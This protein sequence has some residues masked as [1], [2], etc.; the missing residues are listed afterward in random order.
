MADVTSAPRSQNVSSLAA[1][2]YR[3]NVRLVGGASGSEAMTTFT[4]GLTGPATSLV[5]A[6]PPV[7]TLP[8]VQFSFVGSGDVSFQCSLQLAGAL[9][10]YA[11]CTSPACAHAPT[12]ALFC[13][14]LSMMSRWTK[15]ISLILELFAVPKACSRTPVRAESALISVVHCPSIT[16]T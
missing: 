13:P 8:L 11:P 12:Q 14:R 10:S 4:A 16:A 15:D 7:Q 6:P 9:P 2:L 5:A 1:G 3:F